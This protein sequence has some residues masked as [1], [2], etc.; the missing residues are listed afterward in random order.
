MKSNPDTP[1]TIDAPPQVAFRPRTS[2]EQVE[3][4]RELAPE[5][6]RDGL[7]VCVT[8]EADS[9]EV[10]M[11]G[12]MDR[13]ALEKTVQTGEA[14]Y[15]SRSRI[16]LWHR[17]ATSGLVQMVEEM[18]I[19]DD[20]DAV[21]LRVRVPGSGASCPLVTTRAF[22]GAFRLQRSVKRETNSSSPNQ[23]RPSIQSLSMETHPIR[24]SF[25]SESTRNFRD[26][27]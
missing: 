6:D 21:S 12:Y 20:Q 16:T 13:E 3:E 14:H 2:V 9:G 24:Q 17:G 11:L 1:H 18:R 7:I 8:T 15:W 27:A 22:I 5:F 4:G 19:D 26:R 23:A 25:S 10:L